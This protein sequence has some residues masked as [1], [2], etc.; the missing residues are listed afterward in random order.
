MLPTV[1]TIEREE[2]DN[3]LLQDPVIVD[4]PPDTTA[5]FASPQIQCH[6]KFGQLLATSADAQREREVPHQ[7]ELIDTLPE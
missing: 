7:Y 2:I 3:K 4:P 6:R 1:I 5:L